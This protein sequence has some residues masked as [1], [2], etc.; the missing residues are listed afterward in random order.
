MPPVSRAADFELAY[1]PLLA[2]RELARRYSRVRD[3]WKRTGRPG[4]YF[5]AASISSGRPARGLTCSSLSLWR[6][7][8][9]R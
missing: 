4:R 7:A 2:S 1:V 8:N 9:Q 5:S 3:A 6:A